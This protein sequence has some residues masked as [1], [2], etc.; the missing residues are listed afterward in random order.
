MDQGADAGDDYENGPARAPGQPPHHAHPRATPRQDRVLHIPLLWGRS[1][2]A[3]V[4]AH[5]PHPAHRCRRCHRH[6][7]SAVSHSCKT[8]SSA[9]YDNPSY[10]GPGADNWSFDVKLCAKRS[11]G[12]ICT[13]ATVCWNDPCS[14][15]TNNRFT[16]NKAR[17]HLQTKKS[18]RGADPVVQYAN[19]TGLERAL[20]NSSAMG[21]GPYGAGALKYKSGSGRYLADGYIQLDWSGDRKGCRASILFSASPIA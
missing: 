6:T 17:F 13:T 7:A 12:H 5:H 15:G 18:V 16:F 20:E 19:Y 2:H 3:R 10:N 14:S 21:H 11:G 9:T 1:S 4:Q 8:S